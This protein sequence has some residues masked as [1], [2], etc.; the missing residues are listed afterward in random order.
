[1]SSS[2]SSGAASGSNCKVFFLLCVS[3][4]VSLTA[5]QASQVRLLLQQNVCGASD[6][7]DH[8]GLT[9][10]TTTNKRKV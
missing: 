10:A 1:M 6:E 9:T 3:V 5:V 2:A 8:T 7:C 4:K